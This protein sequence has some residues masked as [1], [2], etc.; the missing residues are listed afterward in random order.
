[1]YAVTKNNEICDDIGKKPVKTEEDCK[2]AAN[3]LG[4]QWF[5][6]GSF[7]SR[8][9]GCFVLG[10][11]DVYLN[12]R[13]VGLRFKHSRGICIIGKFHAPF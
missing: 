13:E 2:K 9:G 3:S 7:P 8:P 5:Y 4:L 10:K 11:Y 1:M 6:S 12:E